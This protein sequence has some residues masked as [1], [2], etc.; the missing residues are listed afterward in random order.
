MQPSAVVRGHG[1]W[2]QAD[3][4]SPLTKRGI[5]GKLLN[6]SV[7]SFLFFFLKKR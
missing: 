1:L 5:W 3:L 4:A 6:L 7:H 2:S